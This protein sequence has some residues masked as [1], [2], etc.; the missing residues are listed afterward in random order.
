MQGEFFPSSDRPE[1]LVS[2][3]LPAN[4]SQTE[5]EK[6]TE[7]LER[8]LAGNRNIDHYSTYIGAGAIRFYLPM[9]VL[10][11]N[12]NTA[13]LVVVAKDLAARDRLREQ[14]NTLLAT[15]FSD[16]TSRVS[17]LELGPPVGWPIKYR[18]SGPDYLK[19]REYAGR[20]AEAIGRSPLTREVNQTAGEPER[21]IVLQVNQTAARAAGVSSQSLA[22]TLNT[23]WSGTT[24]TSLR[25]NDRLVDVVLR[26]N[27]SERLNLATLSSLTVEGRGG[28]KVPLSAVATPTWGVDDPVLWRRQRLPFITVQTDLA[29]GMRAE[30]VSNGLRP[31]VD[32]LRAGLPTGYSIVEGGVVAES[33]KGNSSVLNIFT[34]SPSALCCYY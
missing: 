3:T 28:E 4:A 5:T 24:V 18:V 29:P 32:Q 8:A 13:Q 30:G 31:T 15:Q 23:V 10:L 34:P 2:L 12:E 16:L 21:T 6:Q 17:P 7:R 33:E 20:L 9:D 14:L 1:L 22:Q 25:D 27:D 11:D 19:V 26:A